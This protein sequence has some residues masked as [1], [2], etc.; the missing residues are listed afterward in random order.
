MQGAALDI[1]RWLI[2][3]LA[4]FARYSRDFRRQ[5][6]EFM[7]QHTADL[8]A[9][10]QTTLKQAISCAGVGLHSGQHI[11]LTLYPSDI[12][13]GIVFVR[14]DATAG[15]GM[16]PARWYQVIDTRLCT[17]IGNIHSYSVGTIEHL[18]AA[19]NGAGID[20]AVVELNGPEVPILD[21]SAA[22]WMELISTAG[23]REQA[24]ERRI[25]QVLKP[26][27]VREGDKWASLKPA[28]TRRF[29]V[30]IDFDSPV[31]GEQSCALDLGPESFH[32]A[33]ARART[34][35]F[36]EE[37]EQLRQLGLAR[38][39]SLA[40]AVVIGGDQVLNPEG[41]RFNDE[42][43]RHKT[44]DSVGDLYLA[45]APILGNFHGYKPGHRLNHLL[46]R[47]LLEQRDAWTFLEP[48]EAAAS[49]WVQP[50]AAS[51]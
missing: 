27:T 22:P 48:H 30:R 14:S 11:R 4:V 20:N 33:V 23:I 46:L 36:L 32:H 17:Q 9:S 49:D 26:I 47:A 51:A 19:L 34:F 15:Q 50:L 44:L 1:Q 8:R 18:M 41:L 12:N 35:G 24:A 25:I 45:G 43:V 40:N 10:P 29:S 37:V 2:H 39:G 38:G 42:F 3:W 5:L 31:I 28:T 13:S 6:A 7:T 21:G 16:I